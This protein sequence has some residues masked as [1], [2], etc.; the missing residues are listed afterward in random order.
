[1]RL[2]HKQGI[3]PDNSQNVFPHSLAY[4]TYFEI[5]FVA[6]RGPLESQPI[7]RSKVG[8]TDINTIPFTNSLSN[9]ADH[10]LLGCRNILDC[11]Y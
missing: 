11:L 8:R 5:G 7:E 6:F 3:R 2:A 1:M 4:N 10:R 9:D